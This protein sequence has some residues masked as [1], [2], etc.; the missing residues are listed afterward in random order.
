[1][2]YILRGWHPFAERLQTAG[3]QPSFL[4][5]QKQDL[6]ALTDLIRLIDELDIKVL[7]LAGMKGC[8]L[9]RIA[10]RITSRP[11]IIHIRDMLPIGSTVH[12]VQRRLAR[13]TDLALA[14]SGPSVPLSHENSISRTLV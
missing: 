12:F 3:V 2:L 7:H 13:W 11:A 8:L 6:R 1:M 9:G 14:I 4:N 5:R 10:S